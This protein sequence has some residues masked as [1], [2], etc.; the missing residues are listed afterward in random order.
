MYDY[1]WYV[2]LVEDVCEE[3]GDVRVS[4]MH[5]KGSVPPKPFD[6]PAGRLKSQ[7]DLPAA[8]EIDSAAA[9]NDFQNVFCPKARPFIRDGGMVSHLI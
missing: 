9:Q 3:E 4:F 5:P 7:F 1:N 8:G 2:G 6:R